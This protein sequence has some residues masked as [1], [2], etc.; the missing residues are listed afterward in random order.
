MNEKHIIIAKSQGFFML[1]IL[2]LSLFLINNAYTKEKYI[3]GIGNDAIMNSKK[4]PQQQNEAIANLINTVTSSLGGILQGS[5]NEEITVSNEVI[6][7][8][9]NIFFVLSRDAEAVQG[10]YCLPESTYI[11]VLDNLTAIILEL[12]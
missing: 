1:T 12:R 7:Q 10:Y 11:N 9:L 5:G 6:D 8:L 2:L 4:D 3:C